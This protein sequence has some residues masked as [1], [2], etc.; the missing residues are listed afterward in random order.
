MRKL[1]ARFLIDSEVLSKGTLTVVKI[2]TNG[3]NQ[4]NVYCNDKE[5]VLFEFFKEKSLYPTIYLTWLCPTCVPML[6]VRPDV[7]D[8]LDKG[9]DLM[10]PG[11]FMSFS[12]L[13]K[14]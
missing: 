8:F 13:F 6:F 4:L 1:L 3:G 9:A 5:P 2:L 10:L 12:F 14:F 7:F 11:K